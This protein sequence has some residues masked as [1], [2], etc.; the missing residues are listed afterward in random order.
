VVDELEESYYQDVYLDDVYTPTTKAII[1][2][3]ADSS[4]D[5]GTG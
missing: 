5:I 2:S 1:E 3:K 4:K